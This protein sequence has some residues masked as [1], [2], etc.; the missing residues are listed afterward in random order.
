[1]TNQRIVVKRGLYER[2]VTRKTLV[3]LPWMAIAAALTHLLLVPLMYAVASWYPLRWGFAFSVRDFLV[4]FWPT[5]EY[6]V[7]SYKAMYYMLITDSI[8]GTGLMSLGLLLRNNIWLTATI[9]G[10]ISVLGFMR[11][12]S[13]HLFAK[14]VYYT[15][16]VSYF[17][18]YGVVAVVVFDMA[19]LICISPM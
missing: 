5:S 16:L 3:L 11:F 13:Q 10:I 6:P 12:T 8:Q 18:F 14:A 17:L 4:F 1:M 7:T 9:V 15:L 19:R 2:N